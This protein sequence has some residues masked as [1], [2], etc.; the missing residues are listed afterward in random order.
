[1]GINAF[2]EG[3]NVQSDRC[4][5]WLCRFELSLFDFV[6]RTLF[7]VKR[8]NLK[9]IGLGLAAT[10]AL[11]TGMMIAEAPAQAAGLQFGSVLNFSDFGNNGGVQFNG[12]TNTLN[13]FSSAPPP[14]AATGQRVGISG[15]STFSFS[16]ANSGPAP[17][18]RISDVQLSGAGNLRSFTS[19]SPANFGN[20][21]FLSG[22][23]LPSLGNAEVA[24]Q[25]ESFVYNVSE[26]KANFTGKFFKTSGVG[27]GPNPI[28]LVEFLSDGIGEL[29]TQGQPNAPGSSTFSGSIT[30]VPTPA[31]L[32]ALLG[33]GVAALRK[34]KGEE[35]EPGTVEVKA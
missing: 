15:T 18:S 9:T 12:T 14:G 33:M 22:I 11:T 17:V 2:T 34:R 23:N 35:T 4:S 7:K 19:T 13:F 5:L 28:S 1:M 27:T 3:V 20:N 8:M 26:K 32:P 6:N 25:L 31:L 16:G 10:A 29:T 21:V 30:A 24:F